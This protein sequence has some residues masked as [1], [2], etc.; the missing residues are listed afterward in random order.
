MKEWSVAGILA[1][2]MCFGVPDREAH[3]ETL[4]LE[5]KI[6][7]T[8]VVMEIDTAYGGSENPGAVAGRY[9]HRNAHLDIPLMG[10][11]SGDGYIVYEGSRKDYGD[12]KKIPLLP[13]I[14]LRGQG[15]EWQ[16]ERHAKGKKT[17]MPVILRQISLPLPLRQGDGEFLNKL[18]IESPYQYLLLDGVAL[19]R[20]HKQ[21]F[22][23]YALQWWREP[24]SGI[25]SFTVTGG[26]DEATRE[27][28]NRVL[29]DRLWED[30]SDYHSC[31]SGMVSQWRADLVRADY[32]VAIAPTFLN[33]DVLSVRHFVSYDCGGAHPDFYMAGMNISAADGSSLVLEDVLWLGAG[34]PAWQRDADVLLTGKEDAAYRRY[35]KETLA[36]WLVG[37]LKRLYPEHF[38]PDGANKDG[39]DYSSADVWSVASLS[40]GW[41]LTRSGIRFGASFP[42]FQR[43]C[44]N[45]AWAV[46]PWR[47]AKQHPGMRQLDLP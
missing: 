17:A 14:V 42:R 32:Q 29:L 11:K 40:S 5:G 8:P 47:V 13:Q 15:N 1:M 2:L 19:K 36:P 3:A 12:E 4:L 34:Q 38:V 6:G 18:R 33:R 43:S 22:M 28:L 21:T 24:I 16:G 44:D 39:C 41:H 30:V 35:E 26:Y 37:T 31:R 25:L 45:P 20:H 9:F 7:A 27:R 46:I 23:G 10:E